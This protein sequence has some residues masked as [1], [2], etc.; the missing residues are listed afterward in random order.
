[1]LVWDGLD[2]PLCLLNFPDGHINP[3]VFQNI[4]NLTEEIEDAGETIRQELMN[5]ILH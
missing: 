2:R 3:H 5:P 1:M 4:R